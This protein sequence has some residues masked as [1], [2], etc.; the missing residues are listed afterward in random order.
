MRV[1]LATSPRYLAISG[2][3]FLTSNA[4]LIGLAA[5]HLHYALCVIVSGL[6]LTPL[7]YALHTSFTYRTPRAW[8]TFWPYAAAQAVN[9]PAGLVLSWLLCGQLRL[10]MA[11]A[12]PIITVLMFF[13][14]FTSSFWAVGQRSKTYRSA[15]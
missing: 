4:L 14:N 13:W 11:F 5:L 8:N 7:S 6:V 3:C 1:L 2:F 12:A 9:T 15:D 10:A